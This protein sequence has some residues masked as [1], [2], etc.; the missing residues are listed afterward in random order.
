MAKDLDDLGFWD[1][2]S[3]DCLECCDHDDKKTCRAARYAQGRFV[4]PSVDTCD[5][6]PGDKL[7]RSIDWYVF[8]TLLE[9]RLE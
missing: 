9:V 1:R 8:N 3:K 2:F 4:S 5:T 6:I 7:L